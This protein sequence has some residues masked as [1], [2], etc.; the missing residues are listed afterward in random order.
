MKPDSMTLSQLAATFDHTLLK[1]GACRIDIERVCGEARTWK[2]ASVCVHPIW[3]K[4]A[5]LQLAGSKI[6]VCT[7]IGFPHGATAYPALVAETVRGLED[8]A[9][10]FDMVIPY[11]IA[12]S[13]GW[14]YVEDNVRYVKEAAG[15]NIVKATLETSELNDDQIL[16][17]AKAAI[18]GGADYLKTSTG[19]ASGGATVNAVSILAKVAGSYAGVKA[20]GGIHCYQDARDMLN[21]GATRIG[22]TATVAILEEAKNILQH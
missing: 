14:N 3:I 2:T 21:A 20:S 17:T 11:G 19:F 18:R 22:S 4:E 12:I 1:P 7:V 6:Q 5:A 13:E 16:L 9:R 8:G 15:S 10:E